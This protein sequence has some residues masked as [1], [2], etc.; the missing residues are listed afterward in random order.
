MGMPTTDLDDLTSRVRGQRTRVGA[1]AELS[2]A[3]VIGRLGEALDKWE[4]RQAAEDE[5]N[6]A[7]HSAQLPAN[8][9]TVTGGVVNQS[10]LSVT[11]GPEDGQVWD[12]RRIT[13]QGI[14]VA[15]TVQLYR[16][17]PQGPTA[18][19]QVGDLLF[20]FGNGLAGN[21]PNTWSPGGGLILHSPDQLTLAKGTL[22]TTTDI[23]LT[24]E[25]VALDARWESRYLL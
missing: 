22:S 7:C 12:V 17:I 4:R 23:Y 25:M 3:A 14:L 13:L 5:M 6:R 9:F 16:E 20:T 18:A 21:P 19:G 2:L 24:G 10:G 11:L 15:E 8:H 1:A